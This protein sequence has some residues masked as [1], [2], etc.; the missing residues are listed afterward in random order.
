MPKEIYHFPF[1]KFPRFLIPFLQG[2]FFQDKRRLRELMYM[3]FF[4]VPLSSFWC[5]YVWLVMGKGYLSDFSRVFGMDFLSFL[6]DRKCYVLP[7]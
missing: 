5:L 3:C 1:F 4:F 2:F 7:I 6:Y